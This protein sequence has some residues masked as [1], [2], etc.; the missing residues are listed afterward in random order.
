VLEQSGYSWDDIDIYS[1]GRKITEHIKR[2][3]LEIMADLSE[4]SGKP[5]Y[6]SSS[7]L[8]HSLVDSFASG[9]VSQVIL[10]YSHFVSTSSQPV[11][12]ENYLPLA[13]HDYDYTEEPVDYILEPDPLY[14]VKEQDIIAWQKEYNLQFLQCACKLT[15][16]VASGELESKRKDIKE[17]INKLTQDSP[18][19]DINI[20][21]S[22]HNVKLD[23]II[24]YTKENKH[25]TFLDNYKG[26]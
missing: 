17:L 7:S 9:E 26:E 22:I 8:A 14:L 21:R 4:I 23:T 18:N 11:I 13:L 25:Y 5:D 19:V 20:F 10:I 15:S 6:E 16:K 1:V 12:R 3:G 24:G 2:K